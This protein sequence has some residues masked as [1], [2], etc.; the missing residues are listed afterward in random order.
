M[1]PA[2]V[3]ARPPGRAPKGRRPVVPAVEIDVLDP[4]PG[5]PEHVADRLAAWSSE[6]RTS[7][8]VAIYDFEATAG[9]SARVS[10]A[11]ERAA[12]RGVRVRV[13]FNVMRIRRASAPRP[14]KCDPQTIDGLDV[15]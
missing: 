5:D 14:P 13:T 3:L 6:A 11:L 12:A 7:L 15:P 8:D 10:D 4:A 1:L 9:T 2:D